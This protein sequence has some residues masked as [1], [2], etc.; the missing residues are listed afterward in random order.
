MR[1]LLLAGW[2]VVILVITTF[3]WTDFKG[4]A[5]WDSVQWI[6]FRHATE[7]PGDIAGNI[8]LFTPFGY[9]VARRQI[10]ARPTGLL[11]PVVWALGLSLGIEI[12]QVFCHNHFPSTTDVCSNVIGAAIGA[13]L[14][15]AGLD[16]SSKPIVP[17]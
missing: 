15:R 10:A 12:F 9:L 11:P 1:H 3:P 8:L 7:H 2:L 17:P 5:H 4:H 14:P 16:R 6:P 13:A